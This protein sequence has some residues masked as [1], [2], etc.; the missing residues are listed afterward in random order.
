M[1]DKKEV[2]EDVAVAVEVAVKP[3]AKSKAKAKPES[4]GKIINKAKNN[5]YFCGIQI[6]VGGEYDLT[7]DDL[8]NELLLAKLSRADELNMVDWVK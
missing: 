8:K 5:L 3:K 7:I 1:R 2:V 4:I 6:E